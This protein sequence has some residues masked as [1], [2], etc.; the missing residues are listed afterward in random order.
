VA[1]ITKAFGMPANGV[2]LFCLHYGGIGVIMALLFMAGK[3]M[4]LLPLFQNFLKPVSLLIL[5]ILLMQFV[6]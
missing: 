3:R 2:A 6:R 5:I 4:N 1:L